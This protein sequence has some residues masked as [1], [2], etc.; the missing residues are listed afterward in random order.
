MDTDIPR[1]MK[2]I[3]IFIDRVGFPTIAFLLM[4]YMCFVTLEKMTTALMENTKVLTSLG[5]EFKTHD[6]YSRKAF[7]ALNVDE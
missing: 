3:M 7:R 2:L 1:S 5:M 6:E 4:A